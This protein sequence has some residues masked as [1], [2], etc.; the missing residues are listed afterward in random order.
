MVRWPSLLFVFFCS[1]ALYAEKVL[2]PMPIPGRQ[3][4]S[5]ALH[6][7]ATAPPKAA[8]V[9]GSSAQPSLKTAGGDQTGLASWYGSRFHGRLTSSG[10]VYDMNKMTAA[11]KTLPFGTLVRVTNLENEKSV[12]V[13]ITDRG[14]FVAGRIIDLSK[15]AAEA[16]GLTAVGVA[17]VRLH[18]LKLG[19]GRRVAAAKAPSRPAAAASSS[20]APNGL[21]VIVQIGA[22]KDLG[23]AVRLKDFLNKKGFDS[24]Y[25]KAGNITR[26]VLVSVPQ[27]EVASVRARLAKIGIVSV[28][29]R[30]EQRS[31]QLRLR[32]RKHP[33]Q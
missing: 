31:D 10:Q 26:V 4:V 12:D 7:R 20:A 27:R 17:K 13:T 5:A 30:H 9:V 24:I 21:P 19:D 8:A 6:A 22:F 3:A 25:E 11:N 18:I 16:V 14:P 1:Q 32:R 33:P 23:N 15:A 28:L 2:P 29:I